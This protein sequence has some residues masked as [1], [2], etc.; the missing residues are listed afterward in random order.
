MD[1]VGRV[2][3]AVNVRVST[4][5][6]SD[7]RGRVVVV[8]VSGIVKRFSI[9]IITISLHSRKIYTRKKCMLLFWLEYVY[10]IVTKLSLIHISEPTRP[11]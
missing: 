11:Y 1:L 9:L 2:F 7:V 10:G 5:A 8:V 4:V 3:A 6:K